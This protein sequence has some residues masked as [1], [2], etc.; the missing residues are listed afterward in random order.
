MRIACSGCRNMIQLRQ[1][2]K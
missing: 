1:M 2:S